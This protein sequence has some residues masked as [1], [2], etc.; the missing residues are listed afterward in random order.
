MNTPTM[1]RDTPAEMSIE[2]AIKILDPATTRAALY[3]IEYFAGFG[4]E[5]AKIAACEE[6]CRV[7]VRVMR[8]YLARKGEPEHETC[9]I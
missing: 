4:G 7:A 8:D 6:A 1:E 9:G 2:Q 5:E 3:E